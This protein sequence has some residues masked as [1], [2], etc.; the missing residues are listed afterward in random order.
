MRIAPRAVVAA[1]GLPLLLAGCTAAPSAPTTPAPAISVA[2]TPDT[3][4][5]PT[6]SAPA[7]PS[8]EYRMTSFVATDADGA[9]GTGSGGEIDVEFEN[10]RYEIDFDDDD[11]IT[12]K[13]NNRSGRLI[14][15]GS[16]EGTYAGEPSALAFEITTSSGTATTKTDGKTST[17][18]LTQI[19]TL[20]GF[21]GTG[22]ATCSGSQ[23][24][25]KVGSTTFELVQTD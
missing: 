21:D 5:S 9:L 19:A 12:V 3:T 13:S 16:I 17:V 8:G 11:A 10:G 24:T 18:T 23:L 22:S 25:M 20:L 14:V 6:A 4:A 1:A 7:C 2:P 15:D